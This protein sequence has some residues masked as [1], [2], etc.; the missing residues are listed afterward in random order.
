[1]SDHVRVTLQQ[2]DS[3]KR[4]NPTINDTAYALYTKYINN[5]IFIGDII[6]EIT[7]DLYSIIYL[8]KW[9]RSFH[10]PAIPVWTLEKPI[11]LGGRFSIF[12][13]STVSASVIEKYTN[14]S[15]NAL[16][17]GGRARFNTLTIDEKYVTKASS[18]PGVPGWR[19][20]SPDASLK[21]YAEPDLNGQYTAYVL[22]R[23]HK[24]DI[25]S[26]KYALI[27]L[28]QPY[29]TEH[30][31]IISGKGNRDTAGVIS[32]YTKILSHRDVGSALLSTW[33]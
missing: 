20:R 18:N 33:L 15:D 26:F 6:V 16:A 30:Y 24:G 14:G 25:Y 5:G 3:A 9:N 21:S 4:L 1:M 31:Q 28:T 7:E 12:G 32:P 2:L 10:T 17:R 22:K 13:S 8:S 27:S 29:I 23:L 19:S 11:T